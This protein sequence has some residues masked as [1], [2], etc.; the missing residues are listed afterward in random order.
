MSPAYALLRQAL[1]ARRPLSAV[2]DK[3]YREFCPH[4]LG[5]KE[6]HENV[7]VYQFGGTSSTPLPQ[8]GQWRCFRVAK[9]QHL[10]PLD[11]P[12]HTGNEAARPPKC[13]DEIDVFIPF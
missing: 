7:L 9:I 12:W 4:V 13:I 10:R 11:G 5:F 8:E 3:H 2:Y 6:G 1:L